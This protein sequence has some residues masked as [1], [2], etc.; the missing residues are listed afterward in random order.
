MMRI[1][2][3]ITW[4]DALEH[5]LLLCQQAAKE[6]QNDINN[7]DT[8]ND[9]L[10]LEWDKRRP[11]TNVSINS[12][13]SKL[14]KLNSKPTVIETKVA[15][16]ASKRVKWT[17]SML[18]SLEQ[19]YQISMLKHEEIKK[20]GRSISYVTLLEKEW[21]KKHPNSPLSKH[22]LSGKC[23]AINRKKKASHQEKHGANPDDIKVLQEITALTLDDETDEL[24]LSNTETNDIITNIEYYHP[25]L[26]KS[27]S[28]SISYSN[29]P[30]FDAV[31]SNCGCLLYG[32]CSQGHKYRIPKVNN[33]SENI[34]SLY[35]TIDLTSQTYL[36]WYRCSRCKVPNTPLHFPCYNPE[37]KKQDIPNEIQ[38]LNGDVE[39]SQVALMTLFSSTVK[40]ANPFRR[41]W[42]HKGGEVNVTSKLKQQYLGMYSAFITA[43]NKTQDP[44]SNNRVK[45]ALIWLKQNNPLYKDFF[46][47]VE[48]LYKDTLVMPSGNHLKDRKGKLIGEHLGKEPEAIALPYIDEQLPQLQASIDEVAKQHPKTKNV[49]WEQMPNP[50]YA[51][52]HL[53]AKAWPD[54]FPYGSGSW[55]TGLTLNL[56][57]YTKHRLL[58]YDPRWRRHPSWAF[59]C[60]DRLLKSRLFYNNRIR[61]M[62]ISNTGASTAV[63]TVATIE[64]EQALP[65]NPYVQ[66]GKEVPTVISGSKA[67]WASKL[68]DLIAM[69]KEY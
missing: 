2:K 21:N 16:P 63:P 17:A 46:S 25:A 57:E 24:A 47:N 53:E 62:T 41:C 65:K 23:Q 52:P 26:Y 43:E 37:T 55:R 48:T 45:A 27:L 12:L 44:S 8:F 35:I 31:C 22:T 15:N 51:D 32:I 50:T 33:D 14:R 13:L 28:T 69:T 66:Y 64:Q 7:I 38:S 5:D 6:R 30:I 39:K 29:K 10:T 40:R 3:A 42:M 1:R 59:F 67:Y 36:Y 9:L 68:L 11:E 18:E 58:N 49:K 60:Y 34:T 56:T 4:T 20:H 54:L 61:K 19:C